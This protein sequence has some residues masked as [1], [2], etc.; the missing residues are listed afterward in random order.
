MKTE[1]RSTRRGGSKVGVIPALA[2]LIGVVSALGCQGRGEGLFL[3][4][5]E[6]WEGEPPLP[7]T[8]VL[9]NTGSQETGS[10]EEPAVPVPPDKPS[11][12]A[13][14]AGQ[15]E[16][17]TAL[18]DRVTGVE[19]DPEPVDGVAEPSTVPGSLEMD[20]RARNNH[21]AVDLLDH[22]GRRRIGTMTTDLS[23]IGPALQDD[24]T[25]LRELHAAAQTGSDTPVAPDLHA[26][27]P[28]QVLGTNRGIRYGR[29]TGGPADTLS[30]EFNLS[31]SD[32]DLQ[33]DEGFR[34]MLE[35]AGKSWSY[36]IADTWTAWQRTEGELKGRLLHNGFP[37]AT[38]EVGPEGELSTGLEIYVTRGELGNFAGRA[39]GGRSLPSWPDWWEPHFGAIEID[40]DR[41]QELP[42]VSRFGVLMH[43][44]GHLLGAWQGGDWINRYAPYTDLESGTWTGPNVEAVNGGPAPFQDVSNPYEWV[45]GE[46]DPEA[47]SYDFVHSGLCASVMAYCSNAASVPA[48]V[49][50]ALDFA[51]L[52]D[53]GMTVTD[54]ISRPETYGF[55]GWTDHAAFM[56]SVSRQLAVSLADPQPHFDAWN[57]IWQTLDVVDSL[58]ARADVFGHRSTGDVRLSYQPDAPYGTARFA[59]GLFGTALDYEGM[60]PVT[61]DASLIVDL[62]NLLGEASF[63]S[64]AVYREAARERFAGGSLHYPFELSGNAIRGAARGSTLLADFYGPEHEDIAGTVHDPRAGLL[65][66]FGATAEERPVREDLLS[67]AGYAAGKNIHKGLPERIGKPGG[68]RL[69]RIPVRHEPELRIPPDCGKPVGILERGNAKGGARCRFGNDVGGGGPAPCRPRIRPDRAADNPVHRWCEGPPHR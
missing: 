45:D 49:P 30:I 66:S 16:E 19:A 24:E 21:A 33:Q 2:V 69:D 61:G 53:L 39:L 12:S 68:I 1:M 9:G 23:L 14:T 31:R 4:G 34:S 67:N 46:R 29:W 55:A 35:R 26:E 48:F 36:R 38:I 22:W 52:A 60:P 5:L 41:W 40:E 42:A 47:F 10:T 6:P 65:A 43:E 18:E 27:D 3:H 32:D 11:S 64:L 50:H 59:G 8:G 20:V 28:V 58:L 17:G 51:F 54:P 56:L 63:T 7:G 15:T 25:T 13:Q 44:I 37:E 57:G 62:D